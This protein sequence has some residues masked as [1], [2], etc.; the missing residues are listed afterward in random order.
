MVIDKEI[1]SIEDS[2]SGFAEIKKHQD[3]YA[4]QIRLERFTKIYGVIIY[5]ENASTITK[6]EDN[7]PVYVQIRGFDNNTKTPNSTLYGT[8]TILNMSQSL[9][10]GWYIQYFS[11]A[12]YL[13]KGDYFLVLDG[14]EI[15]LSPKPEYHWNFNNMSPNHPELYIAKYESGSWE[16]EGQGGPF[17]YKLIQAENISYYPEDI[18]MTAYIDGTPYKVNNGNDKGKGYLKKESIEYSPGG[19]KFHIQIANSRTNYL[20]FNLSYQIKIKNLI[21]SPTSLSINSNSRNEWTISP[22]IN[23]I[24]SDHSI[25]FNY[26]K[27]WY[28]LTVFRNN[29]DVSANVTIDISDKVII[30]PDNMIIENAKWKIKALSPLFQINLHIPQT[31]FYLGKEL[32]FSLDDPVLSGTYSIILYNP[33]HIEQSRLEK[34]IPTENTKVSFNLPSNAEPGEYQ[35]VIYWTNYTDAGVAFQSF[36]IKTS[37]LPQGL[38]LTPFYIIGA[39]VLIGSALSVSSYVTVKKVISKRRE[40][41]TAVLKRC[42]DILNLK[43]III[44]DIKSGIDLY[45]QSFIEK[46]LDPSLIAGFLQAIKNF[47]G[48]VLD[49]TKNSRIIK[50][51][52]QDSIIIM[53]EFVN[54]QLIVIMKSAPSESFLY[55]IYDLGL[56]IYEKFG[57]DIDKF[58]G[59]LAPFKHIDEL[60][61]KHLNVSLAYPLKINFMKKAKLNN[62]ELDILKRARKFMEDHNFEYFYSIFLLPE[63]ACDPE[64]Y[65][66]ILQLI[67]KGIFLPIKEESAS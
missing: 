42:Q 29:I 59:I 39:I 7:Y 66:I 8:S 30:I 40:K 31:D 49:D 50:L 28:D 36:N 17:L 52:Y 63:N 21:S 46:K 20:K 45:S 9:G 12:I 38:D 62:K 55:S 14:S 54:S 56:E 41:L 5:G 27:S 25:K 34:E 10:E 48:E 15:G 32:Q 24:S 26:P 3:G 11:P 6:P 13:T 67:N 47:G 53:A 51:E 57:K 1:K 19:N 44:V 18:N 23:N 2:Y 58:V 43:Y 22:D 35:V 60:I 65:E 33:L 4:V 16:S 64:D 37:S 61:E